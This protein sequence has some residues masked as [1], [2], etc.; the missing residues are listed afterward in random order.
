MQPRHLLGLSAAEA[1]NVQNSKYAAIWIKYSRYRCRP[2]SW[3]ETV[4]SINLIIDAALRSKVPVMIIGPTGRHWKHPTMRSKADQMHRTEQSLC[5][6]NI[7]KNE[8]DTKKTS[9]TFVTLSS[10]AIPSRPCTCT[11]RDQ[12]Q[13]DLTTYPEMDNQ[14]KR[15]SLMANFYEAAMPHWFRDIAVTITTPPGPKVN[16]HESGRNE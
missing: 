5:S 7:K 16:T 9:L 2:D 1:A 10:F 8:N 11:T 13:F 6:F 15:I 3:S 12:H 14:T 4:D